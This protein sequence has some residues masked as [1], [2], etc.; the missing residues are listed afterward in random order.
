MLLDQRGCGRSV[1]HASDPAR[2]GDQ[3]HLAPGGRP[4]AAAGGPRDRAVAGARRFL[5]QRVGAGLR[6][7]PRSGSPSWSCAASSRCAAASWTSTTTAGPRSS[8]AVR[9]ARPARRRG[10]A[11][12][13]S[14]RTTDLLSTRTRRSTARRRWPGA[15]GRQRRS[16]WSQTR[17]LIAELQPTRPSRW[18]R[19]DREPLLPQRRLAGRESAARRGARLAGIPGVLVQGRYDVAR[20]RVTAYELHQ[21]WPEAHLQIIGARG[22]RVQRARHHGRAGGGDGP[23]RF[24]G[25]TIGLGREGSRGH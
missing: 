17:Q 18:R 10:S 23:L 15:P 21:A 13:S 14:P 25:L 24:R 6:R 7:A 19:P 9:A 3:H 1:P 20:P 8:G 11:A 4:R 5:G 22:S 12:T 16:P 2:P